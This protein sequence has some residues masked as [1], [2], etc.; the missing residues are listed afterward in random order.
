MRVG[1]APGHRVNSPT[2]AGL[3]IEWAGRPEVVCH[4]FPAL[5]F[6]AQYAFR[7]SDIRLRAS[8]D[9]VRFWRALFATTSFAAFRWA[10]HHFFIPSLRRFRASA[11]IR[12][13]LRTFFATT[14][15]P[16]PGGRPRRGGVPT[17]YFVRIE[18]IE[19]M[20]LS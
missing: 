1:D 6:L 5:L 12:G 2:S 7:R 14:F 8:A 18:N 20:D 15:F 13:L 16:E 19:V 4:F 11:D 9:I 3:R 17:E 10:A